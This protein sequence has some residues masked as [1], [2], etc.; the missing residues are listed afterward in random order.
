[1]PTQDIG[2]SQETR[3]GGTLTLVLG[4]L[5]AASTVF[6]FV[7]SLEVLYDPVFGGYD[8]PNWARAV[9]SA[10]LPIGF[11]GTPIAFAAARRGPGRVRAWIGLILMLVALVAFV[12]LLNVMG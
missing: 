5:F 3:T 9:G 1:M 2:T 12:V 7:L 11:F 4:A 6:I 8:V 10:G